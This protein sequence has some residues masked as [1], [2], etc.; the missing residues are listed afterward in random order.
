MTVILQSPHDRISKKI[1]INARSGP[2][3]YLKDKEKKQTV[4][5]I[6]GC[7]KIA[8]ICQ[9]K[10]TNFGTCVSNRIKKREG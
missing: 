8:W 7:S 5:F 1:N 2:E 3:Q 6:V 9:I 10:K 4:D